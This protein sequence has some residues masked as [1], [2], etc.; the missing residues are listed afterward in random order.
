MPACGEVVESVQA[1]KTRPHRREVP[2][3]VRL[4]LPESHCRGQH[5]EPGWLPAAAAIDWTILGSG[6]ATGPSRWPTRPA[7][8]SPPASPATG[9]RCTLEAAGNT[10]DAADP[11]HPAYG[12]PNAYYRSWPA[13]DYLRTLHNTSS[14][15]LAVPVEGRDGSAAR[16]ID[17]CAP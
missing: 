8:G 2:H 10:Y 11:N 15:A 13:D 1:W 14:K 17:R 12:D 16:S 3:P 7:P 5:V 6:S 9:D 4:P